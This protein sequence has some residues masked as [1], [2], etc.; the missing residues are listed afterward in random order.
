[1]RFPW[2]ALGL[3]GAIA[4]AIPLAAT[5]EIHLAYLP[6]DATTEPSSQESSYLS[7]SWSMQD[8]SLYANND[9]VFPPSKSMHVKAPRF[10]GTHI[11]EQ[12]HLY[13]SLDARPLSS[14]EVGAPNSLVR[15]RVELLNRQGDPVTPN[16]VVLDLLDHPDGSLR[17]AKIRIEPGKSSQG[18]PESE[19]WHM[20]FWQSEVGNLLKHTGTDH[21]QNNKHSSTVN[22]SESKSEQNS[23]STSISKTQATA[24]S[25]DTEPS[26][27]T[28]LA[29]KP[30]PDSTIGYIFSPYFAPASYSHRSHRRPH[31]R[32]NDHSFLRLISPVILP[33]F[34]GAVAGLVACLLGFVIGHLV[35]S[36]AF[37]L[38][39]CQKRDERHNL[40]TKDIQV[41]DG[42]Y[43]EKTGLL[44][45]IF[46][47]EVEEV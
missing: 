4:S 15:V 11:E 24:E 45:E 35:M 21:K 42:T 32:K 19:K 8:G 25:A 2:S 37:R 28:G 26:Q 44:P 1:M 39:L 34:L 41:E 16:I 22:N 36:V 46:V 47:T 27:S 3:F 31:G 6:T 13:Y 12:V 14:H 43:S 17:I 10:E 30:S 20:K 33:A 18:T 40:D 7:I 29:A 5:H 9:R 23:D 38:G